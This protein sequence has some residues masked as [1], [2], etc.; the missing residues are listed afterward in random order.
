MPKLPQIAVIAC[1]GFLKLN[2]MSF[3]KE[4]FTAIQ[5]DNCK[6][7]YE[8]TDGV[9]FFPDENSAKEEAAN[10]GEFIEHEGNHYCSECAK[11]DDEDKLIINTERTK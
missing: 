8:N 5:C 4:E 9:S 2:I 10:W 6:E 7:F 3:I 1:G 11:M